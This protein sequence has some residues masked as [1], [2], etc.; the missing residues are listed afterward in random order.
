LFT[1]KDIGDDWKHFDTKWENAQ[2]YFYENGVKKEYKVNAILLRAL[3]SRINIGENW[4]GYNKEFWHTYL[5]N[6][7]YQS[8]IHYLLTTTQLEIKK[9]C[10]KK[11][12]NDDSLL[13]NVLCCYNSWHILNNWQ[14]YS[15]LTRYSQRRSDATSHKEIV[16]LYYLR[17]RLLHNDKIKIWPETKVNQ[18]SYLYGWDIQFTYQSKFF[19]WHREGYVRMIKD[20]GNCEP[21]VKDESKD[22]PEE[23]WYC[24]GPT[25][26]M[27]S[28]TSQFTE[29][30]DNLIEQSQKS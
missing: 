28:Y 27:A 24:F 16:V 30:L 25:Q 8:A 13:Q 22:A 3:L 12:I 1:Q 2:K 5:L 9:T 18:T 6:S 29:A 15:V 11:W 23:K 26:E 21:V 14:G 10:T 19:Q 17:N 7:E 20:L 4:F